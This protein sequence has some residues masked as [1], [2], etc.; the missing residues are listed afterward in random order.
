MNRPPSS[1]SSTG[2]REKL[3]D[4]AEEL[5]SEAGVAGASVRRVIERAH[6][7]LGA[8]NYHFGSKEHLI[9]E[10]IL[11]RLRPI[12]QER[13]RCLDA[14]E[15][16]AG[17]GKL[18]LDA[19]LHAFVAPLLDVEN[20]PGRPSPIRLVG[21]AM[22]DPDDAV[23]SIMIDALATVVARFDAAFARAL[24]SM[25]EARL[26][27][28][29]GSEYAEGGTLQFTDVTVSS[30]TSSVVVRAVFLNPRRELLPGMFVRH[31]LIEGR[32]QDAILV[33]Q[34]AV[35]RNTKAEP[36]AFVVN[37]RGAVETRK[38]QTARATAS[39]RPA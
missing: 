22:K 18:E 25:P 35:T 24:P 4:A 30:D 6:A 2:I 20:Q 38:V 29:D 36:V 21:R 19:I 17:G 1:R 14:I 23:R 37:E 13:L 27:L 12:D 16:G 32:K 8:V 26:L 39:H 15:A 9:A 33:P 3:L 10:A 31:R 11:R 7:N 28:D 34:L 5:I